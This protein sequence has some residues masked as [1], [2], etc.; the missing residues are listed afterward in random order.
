MKRTTIPLE[1]RHKSVTSSYHKVKLSSSGDRDN[2]LDEDEENSPQKEYEPNT[3]KEDEYIEVVPHSGDGDRVGD[4]GASN[5]EG[6]EIRLT[7]RDH[8]DEGSSDDAQDQSDSPWLPVDNVD[9]NRLIRP[10]NV[11]LNVSLDQFE[12]SKKQSVLKV[13]EFIYCN[14]ILARN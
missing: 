3:I 4:H 11:S 13:S 6:V 2:A 9:P 1:D 14:T 10:E 12:S 5:T 8:F 7:S